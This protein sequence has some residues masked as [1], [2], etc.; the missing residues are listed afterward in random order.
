MTRRILWADLITLCSSWTDCALKL[1][2]RCKS[3]RDDYGALD[4]H[5]R[6]LHSVL[7]D[8]RRFISVRDVPELETERSSLVTARQNCLATLKELDAFLS[9]HAGLV[10]E[11]QKRRFELAKFIVR[12]VESLKAKLDHSTKLLQLSLQSLQM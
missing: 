7:E 11:S 5:V 9:R 1:Y 10:G 4:D 8:V 6:V 2:K 12:D 3:A